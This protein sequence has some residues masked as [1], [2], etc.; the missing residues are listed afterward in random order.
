MKRKKTLGHVV[1]LGLG[2][3][4]ESYVDLV[5]RLGAQR[6][7]ADEVWGI[8]AV[9]DVIRCD[10]IFHMDDVRVQEVRAAAAP[11]SNIAA[12]LEWMKVRRGTPIYT[13]VANKKYPDLVAYPLAEVI[14]SCGIAY[15]NSTCAYAVALAVH[16]GASKI[17]LYGSDFTYANSHDAEKGRACVEFHLGI[18]KAR[19]IA[20]GLPRCT[21]LLDANAPQDERIYGYDCVDLDIRRSKANRV[22]VGMKPRAELPTAEAIEARYDH[23]RHPNRLVEQEKE[24]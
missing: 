20:I 14:Q 11:E 24:K 5:K 21:T 7:L 1:I 18:A 15:F 2:P 8:N 13:S 4:L 10:R 16:E 6:K 3:S 12:M 23:S 17:S 9:G 19:G 22:R